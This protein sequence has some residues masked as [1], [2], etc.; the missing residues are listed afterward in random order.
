VPVVG[1]ETTAQTAGVSSTPT[2]AP[3]AIAMGAGVI[4]SSVEVE[5]HMTRN[6]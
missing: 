1:A 3:A 2:A 5:F 4:A 6:S